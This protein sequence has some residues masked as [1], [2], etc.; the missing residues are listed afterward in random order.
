M[1]RFGASRSFLPVFKDALHKTDLPV[2]AQIDQVFDLA[3]LDYWLARNPAV[4][5]LRDPERFERTNYVWGASKERIY[6]EL[7]TGHHWYFD[8]FHRDNKVHYEVFDSDGKKHLG[9]A[10]ANGNLIPNTAGKDKKPIF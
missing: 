6:R 5:D 10:D 2:F 3:D 1:T 7:K 9:E 4:F 8:R